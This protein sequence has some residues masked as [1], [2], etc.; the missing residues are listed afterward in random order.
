M[1]VCHR[2]AKEKLLTE[3][4]I[5]KHKKDGLQAECKE[6]QREYSTAHY[7][8]NKETYKA[9]AKKQVKDRREEINLLKTKLKCEKC[10]FKHPA[11]L[12]F[13]HTDK[14]TKENGISYLA[15]INNK[16]K[17]EE[18]IKKCIVLCSNCHRILHWEENN[19]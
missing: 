2:C 18:E 3:F 14:V 9:R 8:A 15:S 19:L 4:G 12:D 13:H 6:C 11:A 7:K 1:K 16:I 5:S 10:G 17:L